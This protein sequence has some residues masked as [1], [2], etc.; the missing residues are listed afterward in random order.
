MPKEGIGAGPPEA[1][2]SGSY[3]LLDV[4]AGN[5]LRPFASKASILNHWAISPI[6][7]ILKSLFKKYQILIHQQMDDYLFQIYLK[8]HN[9]NQLSGFG[10]TC[11]LQYV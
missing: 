5:A 4:G 1:G 3:D 6:T 2:L 10:Y 9:E 7:E 8:N 11:Y